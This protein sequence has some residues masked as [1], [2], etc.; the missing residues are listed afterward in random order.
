MTSLRNQNLLQVIPIRLCKAPRW[1]SAGAS[2]AA[3]CS[4]LRLQVSR[5][6]L[7]LLLT[8]RLRGQGLEQLG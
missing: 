3:P 1:T 7:N 5:F 4:E 8:P 6:W 2:Q